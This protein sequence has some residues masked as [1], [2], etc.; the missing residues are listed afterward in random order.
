H[1]KGQ[2]SWVQ[3][4]FQEIESAGI[5]GEWE[6]DRWMSRRALANIQQEPGRFFQACI[7]RVGAFWSLC[8]DG[9]A[10][11]ELP[12]LVRVLVTAWYAATFGLAGIGL[13]KVL[14]TDRHRWAPCLLLLA[15]FMAV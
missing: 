10:A 8:P 12:M 5:Q 9:A 15:S 4:L 14:A 6:R 11:A 13:I 1:G 3:T 2:A 7:R